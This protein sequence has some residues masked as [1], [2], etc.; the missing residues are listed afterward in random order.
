[1][2][3]KKL[4]LD[5]GILQLI[6]KVSN[7]E[8]VGDHHIY[9][10]Q[11]TGELI[12]K[13]SFLTNEKAEGEKYHYFFKERVQNKCVNMMR[14]LDYRSM[15]KSDICSKFY[16]FE[17]YYEY[18]FYDLQKILKS[19]IKEKISFM[20]EELMYIFYH[21]LE[22]LCYKEARGNN[23]GRL[24]LVNVFYD[25]DNQIYKL[26]DDFKRTDFKQ[27]F[28]DLL[29]KNKEGFNIFAPETLKLLSISGNQR[30]DYPKI[31]VYHLGIILLILGN[32]TKIYDLYD[33]DRHM[34]N[35]K[36]LN[37]YLAGM[38]DRYSKQNPL[39]IEILK[40]LLIEDPSWRPTPLQVKQKFPTYIEFV[41]VMEKN[42]GKKTP[43][44]N[45]NTRSRQMTEYIKSNRELAQQ[46]EINGKASVLKDM[47]QS[48][49]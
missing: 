3:D 34:I 19:R 15:I 37:S 4:S 49:F 16:I 36:C 7:S 13:K 8:K 1:M 48:Y 28:L 22:A 30:I 42:S 6:K 45:G 21:I 14:C 35:K 27:D 23:T 40:D 12:L 38:Y 20:H 9:Q 41:Q 29:Y 26:I 2:F 33:L 10:N 5:I 24:Q 25:T 32:N 39:L 46:A 47:G 31:D 17:V 44:T 11:E 43:I 18:P